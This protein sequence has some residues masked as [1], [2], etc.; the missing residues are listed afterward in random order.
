V[1]I[2]RKGI[3]GAFDNSD[4][5]LVHHQALLSSEERKNIIRCYQTTVLIDRFVAQTYAA[6]GR[7]ILPDEQAVVVRLKF[8]LLLK[9][10]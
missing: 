7:R 6:I 3:E 1:R 2:E 9:I 8:D 10:I 4:Y 5:V